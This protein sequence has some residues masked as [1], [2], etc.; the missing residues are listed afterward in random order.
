MNRELIEK[1]PPG[2][3]S[4]S[5]I[6]N[7]LFDTLPADKSFELLK[8]LIDYSTLLPITIY[9]RTSNNDLRTK[10]IK[11]YEL[12]IN[13]F[14]KTQVE[15]YNISNNR[16]YNKSISIANVRSLYSDYICVLYFE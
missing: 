2:D 16:T 5:Q 9:N 15:E 12:R 8:V 11:L 14:W 1:Y 10:I 6:Y 4:N 3:R 7:L 13:K